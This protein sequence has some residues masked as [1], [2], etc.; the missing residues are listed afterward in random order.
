MA[1]RT[2][3][4]VIV[5]TVASPELNKVYPQTTQA[6]PINHNSNIYITNRE[7]TVNYNFNTTTINRASAAGSTT[8][9][10]FNTGSS[11]TGDAEFTYDSVNDILTVI[12][13]IKTDSLMYANG[14]AWDFTSSVDFTGYATETYVNNAI[15][16]LINGAPSALDTLKE[17]ADG[18]EGLNIPS[19]ISDLTDTT[20]LLEH[21][22]GNY[23]DLT[24]QPISTWVNGYQ[25]TSK[26]HIANVATGESYSDH[27][28]ALQVNGGVGIGKELHVAGHITTF[29]GIYSGTLS[30]W[31]DPSEFQTP[32]F[33]GRDTDATYI[34]SALINVR[35]SGSADWVAYNDKGTDA[36]G[37]S[38]IGF[39]GSNFS[40]P[41]YSITKSSDGYVFVQGVDDVDGSGHA[42][43]GGNLVIATGGYGTHHD[44][45]FATGGFLDSDEKMRLDAEDNK[46][47]VGG[48]YSEASVNNIIDLDVN[49]NATVRGALIFGDGTQMTNI[50][51]MF[52]TSQTGGIIHAT[53]EGQ[54]VKIDPAEGFQI[55]TNSGTNIWTFNNAGHVLMPNYVKQLTVDSI[56]C[57]VAEDTVIFSSTE[58]YQH[59]IKLLVKVEGSE[60]AETSWE[61]QSCEIMVA[62]SFNGNKVA[63]SVYG[64]VY[65][66]DSPLATFTT[67]WNQ[68][69]N[70]V[71]VLCRPTSLDFGVTVRSFVTELTTSD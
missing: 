14:V 70:A 44:I 52:V 12:G 3:P 43:Q 21:F 39:T 48:H 40:D 35:D 41:L 9:V 13:G 29:S 46:L 25:M 64:L 8:Q 32:V 50:D 22:S 18:L 37:W 7:E 15:I 38:D 2:P 66:S 65:T 33:L 57:N 42:P 31:L 28:N 27:T 19:D 16:D 1:L 23:N 30:D 67:Q 60:V 68:T 34:Q 51:G 26:L 5:D 45:V 58:P 59:T 6:I 63:G 4:Q 62:K 53:G 56:Y 20:N 36:Q 54:F 55:Q 49:G 10:Q 47:Y 11:F 71:E 61:T 24:N 69:T 17:L